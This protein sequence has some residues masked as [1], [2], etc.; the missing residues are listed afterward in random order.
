[1]TAPIP[2]NEAERLAALRNYEILD[3]EP[4][5]DFDDIT[6]LAS[7]ICGTPIALISLIDEDRQWFKSKARPH[8]E[9]NLSRYLLLRARNSAARLLR[10]ERCADRRKVRRKSLSYRRP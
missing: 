10:S 8:R 4:E 6:R 1:M 9:R 2:S 3:T 5:Q 7:H